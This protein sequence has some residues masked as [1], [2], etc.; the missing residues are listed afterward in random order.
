MK[1]DKIKF[2]VWSINYS[3]FG[4]YMKKDGV[5]VEAIYKGSENR[6]ISVCRVLWFKINLPKHVWFNNKNKG[7]QG[8]VV[9]FGDM[10]GKEY[11]DWLVANNPDAKIIFLYW[12]PIV[13]ARI[14]IDTVKKAGCEVWSYG[15]EQCKE[16]NIK[17]N[18]PFYCNSMYEEARKSAGIKEYDIIFS[19]KDKGRL[20]YL[21]S[22]MKEPYWKDLKWNLYISPDHFWQIFKKK[23]YKKFLPYDKLLCKQAA[24][25]AVL[26]LVPSS[27][28][29]T[30]MRTI[31]AMCLHQKLITNNT[32][33]VSMNYYDGNNIFVMG[34]DRAEDLKDF[35]EGPFH[36]I[37]EEVWNELSLE[38]WVERFVL[39]EPVN[40]IQDCFHST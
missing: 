18:L 37:P 16:Y 8:K 13:L 6:L 21:E 14:D 17:Q 7:M 10:V 23:I 15:D 22:L 31:D 5:D 30:T 4:K 12:D 2:L 40:K 26:E 25:K 3:L 32:N 35:I 1:N 33:I 11:L 39:D 29:E 36:P 20:G 19:G 24:S 27:L 38:K 9:I 34:R 28:K